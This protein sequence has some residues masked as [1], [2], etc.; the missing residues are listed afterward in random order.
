MKETIELLKPLLGLNNVSPETDLP[1]N[2]LTQ[3]LNVNLDK[4]GNVYSRKGYTKI[5]S[6]TNETH[7]LYKQYFQD[8]SELKIIIDGSTI[9]TGLNPNAYLAWE[10]VNLEPIYSD[11]QLIRRVPDEPFSVPTPPSQPTIKTTTGNLFAGI[12]Q[13]T[14][15]FVKQGE[16]GGALLASD[17]LVEDNSGITLSNLPQADGCD[18][19]VFCTTQNGETLYLNQI[20]VAGTTA[21]TIYNTKNNTLICDTQFMEPLPAGHILRHFNARLYSAY[22]NVLYY[23]RPSRYGLCKLGED[24]F[25][26]VSKI[27]IVQPVDDGIFIVSDKTYFLTGNDP[28]EMTL[29]TVSPDT[30]IE[31][32]GI[33]ASASVFAIDGDSLVAYWFS[34]KGAMIGM[35]GGAIKQFTDNRLA[36]DADIESGTTVYKEVEGIR[37]MITNL[38]KGAQSNFQFGAQATTQIIRNGVIVT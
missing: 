20:L 21:F 30:A 2:S 4:E 37:Q 10:T 5:Y 18:I 33:T 25:Q 34:N 14:I 22:D 11:G 31:G 13:V 38:Q 9:A 1:E 29:I 17:L 27:T 23:S 8:G 24:F 16:Q 15:C 7:S 26:F 35:P 12:Y 3:A 19:A 32:T 6:A 36:I 28:D